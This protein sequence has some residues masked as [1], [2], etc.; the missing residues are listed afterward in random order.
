MGILEKKN[1]KETLRKATKES[2]DKQL[3]HC[4]S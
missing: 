4:N 2:E 1:V 3:V